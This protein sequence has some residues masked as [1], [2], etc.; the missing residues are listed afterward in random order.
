MKQAHSYNTT[1]HTSDNLVKDVLC[2]R[3]YRFNITDNKIIPYYTIRFLYFALAINPN[4]NEMYMQR[5]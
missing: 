5:K 1:Y 4:A 2:L 3:C